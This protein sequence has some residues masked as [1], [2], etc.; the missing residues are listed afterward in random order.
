MD[1]DDLTVQQILAELELHHKARDMGCPTFVSPE[2][3]RKALGLPKPEYDLP[4]GG[5]PTSNWDVSPVPTPVADLLEFQ[6]EV[7]AM[8]GQESEFATAIDALR[9][10]IYTAIRGAFLPY[11]ES[12]R[13]RRGHAR[14]RGNGPAPVSGAGEG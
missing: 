14:H 2:R 8:G 1:G 3:V 12:A 10:E 9:E 5:P 4:I 6:R 7:K 13:R 11:V